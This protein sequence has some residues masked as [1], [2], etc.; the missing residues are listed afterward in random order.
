M[1]NHTTH[2]GQLL[3]AVLANVSLNDL[4][5]YQYVCN[6]LTTLDIYGQSIQEY[7]NGLLV[8]ISP[9]SP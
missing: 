6:L 7:S 3:Q 4:G 8:R 1:K 5:V 9:G 2:I